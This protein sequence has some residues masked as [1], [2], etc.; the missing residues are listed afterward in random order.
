[1][2]RRKDAG[3]LGPF[4]QPA[5]TPCPLRA[6]GGRCCT[7]CLFCEPRQTRTSPNGNKLI[8][9]QFTRMDLR[10]GASAR[11]TRHSSNNMRWREH[12]Y[13]SG[14]ADMVHTYPPFPHCPS[15]AK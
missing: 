13:F 4:P 3:H 6:P 11:C 2:K 10:I 12:H 14:I 1:M 5:Q 9:V 8:T 7:A 15:N